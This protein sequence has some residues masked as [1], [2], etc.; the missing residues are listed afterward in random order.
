MKY[1]KGSMDISDIEN[2]RRLEFYYIIRG[3][4]VAQKCIPV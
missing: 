3:Y 1:R 2:E 4:T